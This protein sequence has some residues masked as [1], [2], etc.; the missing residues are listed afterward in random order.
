M[1]IREKHPVVKVIHTGRLRFE[2]GRVRWG[3]TMKKVA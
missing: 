2:L 3:G 1:E